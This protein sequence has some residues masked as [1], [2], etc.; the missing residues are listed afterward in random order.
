LDFEY[1]NVATDQR[2]FITTIDYLTHHELYPFSNKSLTE[3]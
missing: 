3:T 2:E 1:S